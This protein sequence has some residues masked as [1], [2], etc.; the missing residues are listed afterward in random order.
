QGSHPNRHAEDV[1][2]ENGEE[3]IPHEAFYSAVDPDYSASKQP[4]VPQS[5]QA[6]KHNTKYITMG[7]TPGPIVR[8]C[9][10]IFS[11][12]IS[13]SLMVLQLGLIDYYY[14]D[15]L[16]DNVWYC[17]L[18]GDALVVI[19]FIW[20]I[21]LAMRSNQQ[22]MEETSSLDGKVRYAW[23][24][25]LVYSLLLVAKITTCFRLFYQE[26]PPKPLDHNDKLLDD[27]LL[28]LC[29]CLSALIFIFLLES[30]HYTPT[31]S[32]RQ[33]YINYLMT[34]ICLDLLDTVSFIDLLWQNNGL[35]WK[36]PLWLEL[37][38]LCI[39][40]VNVVLPTFALLKLRF[41]RNSR[42]LLISD[43][44]WSFFYV[45][46]VNGPFLA[47]RIY[48]YVLLECIHKKKGNRY[49]AS[50]FAIKNVAMVY[51]ALRELW[52]RLHYWRQKRAALGSR[53]ELTAQ[54]ATDHQDN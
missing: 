29:L 43:R 40:C 17:W 44:V 24:A 30:H 22:T 47:F 8:G 10:D 15:N 46:L 14:I 34:A 32:P 48:L 51:I 19:I 50:I 16:K 33:L 12:I 37:T 3:A 11:F 45:L 9:I 7:V 52:V 13:L 27:H 31:S 5:I 18:G 2:E 28:K 26:L 35:M 23:I 21:V 41:N 25:W 1:I 38:I 54:G 39:G 36:L 20:L 4:F 49:D 6:A 53:G 42:I